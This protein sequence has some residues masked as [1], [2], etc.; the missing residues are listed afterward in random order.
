MQFVRVGYSGNEILTDELDRNALIAL[1]NKC[2]DDE[3]DIVRYLRSG[4]QI[5]IMLEGVDDVIE[6]F[7]QGETMGLSMLID[8]VWA[9][10]SDLDH[11]LMKYHLMLPEEFVEHIRGNNYCIPHLE[12]KTLVKLEKK[13][14]NML[15]ESRFHIMRRFIKRLFG[16]E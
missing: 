12:N 5:I 16:R 6:N 7:S 13:L 15:K 11:Y 3:E 2:L 14:F 4:I 9:W 10:R 1:S 8:G